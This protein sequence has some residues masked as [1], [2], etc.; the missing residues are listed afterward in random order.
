MTNTMKGGAAIVMD[1]GHLAAN[2]RPGDEKTDT[3]RSDSDASQINPPTTDSNGT[4]S[5]LRKK[6]KCPQCGKSTLLPEFTE[7]NLVLTKCS[8]CGFFMDMG[9]DEWKHM[10]T[11]HNF[12]EKIKKMA[13]KKELIGFS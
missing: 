3:R 8:S 5:I 4:S 13:C 6:V 11:G 2:H 10:E 9:I 7:Q 1:D 12:D